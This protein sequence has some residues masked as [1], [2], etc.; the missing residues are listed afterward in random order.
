MLLI[1]D[2]HTTS[3]INDKLINSLKNFFEQNSEE[4]NIVFLWDYVYH[5]SY[6]RKAI[7]ELYNLFLRLFEKWKNIYILAW[8]HDR[9]WNYFVYQEA[10]KAFNI[11]NNIKKSDW[12]LSFITQPIIEN[13]E[14]E[15]IL[16]FPFSIDIANTQDLK[17]TNPL[18]E[19]L[20]NSKNKSEQTS[21]QINQILSNYIS[22]HQK[23]T[24]IHH[25]YINNTIF[26]WQK[27]RFWYKDICLSNEFLD[28]SDIRLISWHLH[29]AFIHK[30]YFCC[31]SVR[32]TTP[33]EI[34]QNKFLFKYKPENN[35]IEWF[36]NDIN[37]YIMINKT[38][39]KIINKS[40]IDDIFQ[41]TS[42]EN[43]SN[44]QSNE[45]RKI[46]IWNQAQLNI[47]NASIQI[48]V[49]EI[50]YE[51]IETHI[52]KDLI[53]EFKDIKLK[54]D[55][56]SIWEIIQ[57]FSTSAE[58]LKT[59]FTDRKTILKEYIENKFQWDSYKYEKIL[60]DLNII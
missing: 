17:Y 3:R 11:I 5:F 32:S 6:D 39:W 30:N 2:I 35:Y 7:L 37:P 28:N 31:G 51:N 36:F 49:E 8:N 26:P 48:K 45:Y 10:Q 18:R 1:G 42:E 44:L 21:W 12:K 55:T 53:K 23:L 27:S 50:N 29:Q 20:S 13:I 58:N 60:K 57:N 47:S 59:W 19:E 52:E 41:K 25:Y 54:K 14:W 33:L 43:I 38:Q 40:S 9:L 15:N 22:E 4:K 56:K 34:N 16:F 46:Q 24:I